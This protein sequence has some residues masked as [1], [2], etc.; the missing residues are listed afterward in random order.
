MILVSACLLGE[1]VRYD[2]RT[3]QYKHALMDKWQ[4][5]EQVLS[6]CPETAGGLPVPR[7]RAEIIGCDGNSVI[8]GNAKVIAYEG[9]DVTT[10]FIKGAQSAL[11]A[12]KQK[13]IKV[14]ILKD[15]SPSCGSSYIYDGRFSK[16]RINGKGVTTALLENNGIRVFSE[17]EIEKAAELLA[18]KDV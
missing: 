15:G 16:T 3:I 8:R 7:P 4:K 14:A 13:S 1:P 17:H 2:G 9:N 12:A 18:F 6:F 10:E 5:G 11:N